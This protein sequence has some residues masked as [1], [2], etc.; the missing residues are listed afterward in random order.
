MA[1]YFE[2]TETIKAVKRLADA[3]IRAAL[4]DELSDDLV[5]AGV[6]ILN[7]DLRSDIAARDPKAAARGR[8]NLFFKKMNQF[9]D[10]LQNEPAVQTFLAG[11]V[12]INVS[13]ISG[14]QGLMRVQ[15][16][17]VQLPVVREAPVEA[18]ARG[19]ARFRLV[20]TETTTLAVIAGR[21]QELSPGLEV[22]IAG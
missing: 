4:R 17:L 16:V 19:T 22:A 20:L 6:R 12:T 3:D 8:L 5:D 14:F 11:T 7:I 9:L 13:P 10:T 21:V 2:T 1:L 18:Y 15:D